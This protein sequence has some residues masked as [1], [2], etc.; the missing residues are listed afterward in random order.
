[1]ITGVKTKLLK[2]VPD[3]SGR[4]MEIL[5]VATRPCLA[6][7]GGVYDH[8]IFGGGQGLEL[9]RQTGRQFCRRQGT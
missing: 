3:E 4:L 1:M 7:L 2:L 9:S 8:S 6:N 5:C